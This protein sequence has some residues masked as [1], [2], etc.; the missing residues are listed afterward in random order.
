LKYNKWLIIL[1]SER[2]HIKRLLL[3]SYCFTLIQWF[4]TRVS[5]HKRVPWESARGAA[6]YVI[7]VFNSAF[8]MKVPQIVYFGILGC[9][10]ICFSPKG[11]LEP[12]RLKNT[13][14]ISV[15]TYNHIAAPNS[16]P[17][18]NRAMIS[19][20]QLPITKSCF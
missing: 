17:C 2:D 16:K 19:S 7:T 20:C 4:S 1:S 13:A 14:L 9:R 10:Q 6:N 12:K 11:G 18:W 8:T 15:I 3:P 5:R